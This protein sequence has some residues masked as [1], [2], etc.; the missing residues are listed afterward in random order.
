MENWQKELLQQQKQQLLTVMPEAEILETLPSFPMGQQATAFCLYSP[1]GFAA[2]ITE[3]KAQN[4]G[5]LPAYVYAARIRW[6]TTTWLAC[7]DFYGR[8]WLQAEPDALLSRMEEYRAAMEQELVA[9]S[10]AN[11]VETI[12]EEWG[13]YMEWPICHTS[14]LRGHW[15]SPWAS[16]KPPLFAYVAYLESRDNRG[17]NLCAA[18]DKQGN[19]WTME[20]CL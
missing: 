8:L 6:D 3:Q 12:A 19:L 13:F 18:L 14:G 10:Y 11:S 16:V 2:Q 4:G 5:E 9:E 15:I 1:S 20:I 17:C 7:L